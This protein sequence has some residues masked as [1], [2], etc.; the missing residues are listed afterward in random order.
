MDGGIGEE[1]E[2]KGRRWKEEEK[3][4]GLMERGN[5]GMDGVTWEE[6]EEKKETG[7]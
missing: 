5:D 4:T 2:S 6:E 7:L 1:E 3:M